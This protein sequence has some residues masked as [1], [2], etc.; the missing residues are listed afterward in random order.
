MTQDLRMCLQIL[1]EGLVDN[2]DAV[3]IDVVETDHMAHFE[4]TVDPPD[5]GKVLGKKGAYAH[6][7]YFQI[8]DT[9]AWEPLK[10]QGAFVKPYRSADL[11]FVLLL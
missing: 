1:I 2:P 10:E 8:K 3:S 5:F 9:P 11:M 6:W 7:L 4:I